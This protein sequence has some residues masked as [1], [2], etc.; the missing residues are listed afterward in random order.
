MDAERLCL[1]TQVLQEVFVTLTKKLGRSASEAIA[2]IQDLA[3]YPVVQVD[4][5][6]ILDAARLA[7]SARLSFWDALLV[8]SAARLGAAMLLTEHLNRGQVIAGVRIA[9]PFWLRP[10][11]RPTAGYRNCGVSPTSASNRG[12]R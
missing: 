2:V 8:L 6:A 4:A 7:E 12:R 3:A 11:V 5:A 9:S 10:G 1:S